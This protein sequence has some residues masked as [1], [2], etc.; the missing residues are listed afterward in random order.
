MEEIRC[1]R[2]ECA[3]C[4]RLGKLVAKVEIP[5]LFKRPVGIALELVCPYDKRKKVLF[6]I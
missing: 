4:T 2:P 1:K 3:R 6:R 5:P